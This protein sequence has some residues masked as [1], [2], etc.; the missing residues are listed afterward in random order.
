[1]DRAMKRDFEKF[2]FYRGITKSMNKLLAY[3]FLVAKN[4]SSMLPVKVEPACPP[5]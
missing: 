4:A 1:M 3:D 5:A 2:S